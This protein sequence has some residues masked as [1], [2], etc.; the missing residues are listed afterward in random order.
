[1]FGENHRFEIENLKFQTNFVKL[2]SL[3]KSTLLIICWSIGY[4]I[5][6]FIIYHVSYSICLLE[7][8]GTIFMILKNDI[9]YVPSHSGYFIYR[10]RHIS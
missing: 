2:H 6:H 10:L 8:N 4:T 9:L 1:M 5:Y 7:I 3:W